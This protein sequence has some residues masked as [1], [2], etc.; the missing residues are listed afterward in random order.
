MIL[1]LTLLNSPFQVKIMNGFEHL[2]PANCPK[3]WTSLQEPENP[4]CFNAGI[5]DLAGVFS[6][7]ELF[8]LKPSVNRELLAKPNPCKDCT[9]VTTQLAMLRFTIKLSMM[10]EGDY[11]FARPRYQLAIGCRS[12]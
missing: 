3:E 8:W 12:L 11:K 5:T 6:P 10:P 2:R 1:K 4:Q 9:A 7:F